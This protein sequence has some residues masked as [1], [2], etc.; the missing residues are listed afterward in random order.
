MK[1][2]DLSQTPIVRRYGTHGAR[3][4]ARIWFP[5]LY[6]LLAALTAALWIYSPEFTVTWQRIFIGSMAGLL[7]VAAASRL[8]RM[9]L[10]YLASLELLEAERRTGL[11]ATM[12]DDNEHLQYLF[13]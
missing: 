9:R 11:R 5:L 4:F 10:E 7:V 1:T 2:H 12:S 6:V 13:Q 3:W 8:S